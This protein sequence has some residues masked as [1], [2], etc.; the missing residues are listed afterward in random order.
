MTR[1]AMRRA[2]AL[3]VLLVP[4]AAAAGSLKLHVVD[5]GQ[6]DGLI[7]ECP[8]GKV[9]MIVDSA[10]G[11]EFK[12]EDNAV[13]VWQRYVEAR[14]TARSTVPLVI[15]THPHA[16]HISG[17]P[18]LLRRNKVSLLVD[19][20]VESDTAVYKDYADARDKG[21]KVTSY[22]AVSQVTAPVLLCRK[23]VKVTLFQAK[24]PTETW[25]KT[26]PNR[27]S[28][29]ARVEY[30]K[31]SFLL[32]GDAE[33]SA[34]SKLLED[35]DQAKLLDVDVLK[36]GHH[37]SQGASSAKFLEAVSPTCAVISSGDWKTSAKNAGPDGYHHPRTTAL[38]AV[39]DSLPA[40]Q[41]NRSERIRAYNAVISK[42]VNKTVKEGLS[43]TA[44]DGTVVVSSDGAKVTCREP[45]ATP[46]P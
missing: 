10:D 26:D 21:G 9:G 6:G 25:C 28:V 18:W 19:S 34:E 31:T 1:T 40:E 7:L 38:D 45:A 24:A 15:A 32:M 8:D 29:I 42:W 35:P 43:V 37:G 41:A 13:T 16:D 36:V 20:G 17:L 22:K 39:D 14:L 11:F 5:V 12:G 23:A 3:L 44:R 30:K 46:P 27:C 33:K 2:A 4:A